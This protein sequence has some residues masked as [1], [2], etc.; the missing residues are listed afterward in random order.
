MSLAQAFLDAIVRGDRES[1]DQLLGLDR[2]LVNLRTTT[3]SHVVQLAA[4]QQHPELAEYLAAR[5]ATMDLWN[6]CTIGDANI[7]QSWCINSS[8]SI[9][10]CSEDGLLPLCLAAAFGHPEC[11]T[12]LLD[13]EANVDLRSRAMGGLSPLDAAVIGPEAQCLELLL[14]HGAN[15]NSQQE[16]GYTALHGATMRGDAAKVGLLLHYKARRN[17]QTGDGETALD[18]ATRLGHNHLVPL[19]ASAA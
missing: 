19:I 12:V 11:V 18:L 8:H 4:Y 14:R 15:P 16:N 6:A 1:V 5:G 9:N 13:H 10:E 7:T 17:L 3:G 2:S